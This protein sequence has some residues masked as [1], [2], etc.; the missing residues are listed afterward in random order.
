MMARQGGIH[1]AGWN[2]L[3]THMAS[4]IGKIGRLFH[5]DEL[6]F[7]DKKF[8]EFIIQINRSLNSRILN[9]RIIQNSRILN[10]RILNSKICNNRIMH[11][12]RIL[13]SRIITFIHV[14]GIV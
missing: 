2:G 13:N 9:S 4:Q 6:F 8:R 1:V 5:E 14:D 12:S 3:G 7:K 10:S 11:N